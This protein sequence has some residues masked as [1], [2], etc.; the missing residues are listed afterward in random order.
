MVTSECKYIYD[1]QGYR[2]LWYP[3]C[4]YFWELYHSF[5]RIITTH[6]DTSVWGKWYINAIKDLKN[7][8]EIVVLD[9]ARIW[10]PVCVRLRDVVMAH[11]SLIH[12]VFY[13]W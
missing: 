1:F 7:T 5:V 11:V 4:F 10:N 3:D 6:S 8:K 2:S 12:W 13:K 9:I